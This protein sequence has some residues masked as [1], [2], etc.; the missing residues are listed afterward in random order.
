MT[1]LG[2]VSFLLNS[3]LLVLII[4]YRR[5][6]LK[7]NDYKLLCSMIIADMLVG[8]FGILYGVLLQHGEKPVVYKTAAIIPLFST[9]FASIASIAGITVNRLIAVHKPLRYHSIVTSRRLILWFVVIWAFPLTVYIAQLCIFMNATPKFELEIRSIVTVGFFA[10][11]SV[12]LGIPNC[13]MYVA[14]RKQLRLIKAHTALALQFQATSGPA[15]RDEQSGYGSEG[16][17]ANRNGGNRETSGTENTRDNMVVNIANRCNGTK[18]VNETLVLKIANRFN[19]IN[20]G[21]LMEDRMELDIGNTRTRINET[22]GIGRN[23]LDNV[24]NENCSQNKGLLLNNIKKTRDSG[25]HNGIEQTVASGCFIQENIRQLPGSGDE[26]KLKDRDTRKDGT[27]DQSNKHELMRND[28]SLSYNNNNYISDE[29]VSL[30]NRRWLVKLGKQNATD[31]ETKVYLDNQSRSKNSD[32]S[33]GG[34]DMAKEYCVIQ[35]HSAAV[36]YQDSDGEIQNTQFLRDKVVEST[37]KLTRDTQGSLRATMSI[38]NSNSK[39]RHVKKTRTD[40]QIKLTKNVSAVVGRLQ[41]GRKKNNRT[42][43]LNM[44]HMCILVVLAFII[45][46]LPLSAYRLRYLLGMKPIVWFRRFAL[47]LAAANSLINPFIYLLKQR[48]LRRHIRRALTRR[49]RSHIESS[50]RNTHM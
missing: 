33:E 35:N 37:K 14:I 49:S 30:T 13:V 47:F 34:I 29:L 9:M 12:A 4:H 46:W 26:K 15:G 38:N 18:K 27:D 36:I 42:E 45:C 16:E 2:A 7:S 17:Q 25:N 8:I 48:T 44:A 40:T 1:C 43:N 5:R 3:S 32:K 50:L 19:E 11:G 31:K 39:E 24:A 28:K 6:L 22:G 41:I 21:N 20:D 10:V 23:I